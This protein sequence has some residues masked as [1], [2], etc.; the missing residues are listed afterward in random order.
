MPWKVLEY[1]TSGS[2]WYVVNGTRN[3]PSRD[4]ASECSRERS[5]DRGCEQPGHKTRRQQLVRVQALLLKT[6]VRWTFLRVAERLRSC[7]ASERKVLQP[8]LN[9]QHFNVVGFFSP[10]ISI[11]FLPVVRS[12][13]FIHITRTF[14]HPN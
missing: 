9:R 11:R 12:L 10:G 4:L 5:A 13:V 1:W 14:D 8:T 6:Q 7:Y 3:R 2:R